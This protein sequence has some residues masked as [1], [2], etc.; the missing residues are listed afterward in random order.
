VAVA[1]IFLFPTASRLDAPPS[2]IKQPG[3]EADP[4]PQSSAKVKNI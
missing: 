2:G 1:E 3:Y 4:S